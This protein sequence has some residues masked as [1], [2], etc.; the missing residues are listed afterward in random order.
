MSQTQEIQTILKQIAETKTYYQVDNIIN[1]LLASK[2]TSEIQIFIQLEN[3]LENLSPL[4]LTSGEW[5]S[6][7]YALI[8]LR[9]INA[10]LKNRNQHP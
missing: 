4:T 10:N 2:K 7:R 8:C 9:K 3:K 6:L 5:S 1:S